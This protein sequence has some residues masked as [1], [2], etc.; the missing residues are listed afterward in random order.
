MMK[1]S[2]KYDKAYTPIRK[3][4]NSGS[5]RA[6]DFRDLLKTA[7]NTRESFPAVDTLFVHSIPELRTHRPLSVSC[8]PSETIVGTYH[9]SGFS[10]S[11]SSPCMAFWMASSLPSGGAGTFMSNAMFTNTFRPFGMAMPLPDGS[12]KAFPAGGFGCVRGV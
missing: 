11:N 5:L 6:R 12:R 7:S 8:L 10:S 2:A 3:V 4:L 9:P 1:N